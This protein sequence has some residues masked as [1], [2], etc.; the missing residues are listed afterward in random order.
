VTNEEKQLRAMIARRIKEVR[1]QKG[2][3]QHD[4]SRATGLVQ[5]T[6]SQY[7]A[8]QITLNTFALIRISE[9]LGCTIDYLLGRDAVYDKDNLRGRLFKAFS[10]MDL[11][12][13][14]QA[15]RMFEFLVGEGS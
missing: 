8:G 15:V 2:M 14:D 10:S 5:G 9:G 11:T 4:L 1:V 3:T 6:V 12:E 7:E 13:Q